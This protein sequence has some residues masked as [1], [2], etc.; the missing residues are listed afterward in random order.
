MDKNLEQI[1]KLMEA[2]MIG[3]DDVRKIVMG[4]K[5]YDAEISGVYIHDGEQVPCP[6]CMS[7]DT[8]QIGELVYDGVHRK[9]TR[10]CNYCSNVFTANSPGV[11]S[12][13]DQAK[14]NTQAD[15]VTF[16]GVQVSNG[17]NVSDA[18]QSIDA[19]VDTYQME[20][21]I[22]N[23]DNT[24][25]NEIS[26]LRSEISNLLYTIKEI[27]EQNAELQKKVSDPLNGIRNLVNNFN[28]E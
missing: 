13:I 3:L 15:S 10:R 9:G 26:M 20:E 25:Q 7:Y 24:M 1:K 23:L 8:K 18:I 21:A 5:N 6:S 4:E 16:V 11:Q 14:V 22:R 27:A 17:T 19:N 28:L 2:E 12:L